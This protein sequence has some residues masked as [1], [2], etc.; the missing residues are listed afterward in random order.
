LGRRVGSL[1]EVT[2]MMYWNHGHGMGGWG[3][4][5]MSVG[6]LLFWA[7]LIVGVALV[8]RALTR[9]GE[10]G[11]PPAE[12][13]P[14][15]GGGSAGPSPEQVLAERFAR[16]EIDEQEYRARLAVLRDAADRLVKH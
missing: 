16:G 9:T 1:R 3:W 8:V 6:T 14:S 15:A 13:R 4:F 5:A 12:P 7:V 10:R 2:V 11:R